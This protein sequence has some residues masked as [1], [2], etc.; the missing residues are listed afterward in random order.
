MSCYH[1]TLLYLYDHGRQTDAKQVGFNGIDG[2]Q[3]GLHSYPNI[4]NILEFL[5][6]LLLTKVIE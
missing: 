4:T 3:K 6:T 2:I 5:G 1:Y